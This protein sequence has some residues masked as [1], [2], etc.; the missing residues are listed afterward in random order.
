MKHAS[1]LELTAFAA[2][3][4]IALSGCASGGAVSSARG[5]LNGKPVDPA[6]VELGE[7]VWT[8]KACHA[9]HAFGG[10]L[11]GPDLAGVMERRETDWLRK[12]LKETDTML[13]SDP[14]AI[15]MAKDFHGQRMPN[16][17]LTDQQIEALFHYMAQRTA[18]VRAGQGGS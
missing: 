2:F 11:G 18:E 9:C 15:A 13:M 5:E 4:T 14:Q 12:W 16:M 6:Q 3:A 7:T 8:N 17:K 10:K 1:K